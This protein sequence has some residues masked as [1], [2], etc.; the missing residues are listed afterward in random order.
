MNRTQ[1]ALALSLSSIFFA[2]GF[3][4]AVGHAQQ[5]A[6]G[7]LKTVDNPGGG[8]FVYGS[9]TN[10]L[11]QSDA[12]VFM[13]RQ[14]HGHFGDRP[15][16]GKLFQSRDGSSL[17]TFFTLTAKT[18]GNKSMAG[19]VI[20]SMPKGST[21]QA[22]VLYDDVKRF[23]TTEPSMMKTLGALLQPDGAMHNSAAQGRRGS[24]VPTPPSTGEQ[25]FPATAGDNSAVISLPAGWKVT[26][27]SGG[28]L[29]AEGSHGE[30][31]GL[32]MLYQGIFDPRNPQ[33]RQAMSFSRGPHLVCALS[34]D[35]FENYVNVLNQIRQTRGK[36]TGT[37]NKISERNLPS[38]NTEVQVLEAIYT[39]DFHDGKGLR[40]GSARVGAIVTRGLPSWAMTVSATN[41]P[42]PL[43]EEEAS[44]MTAVI[45]SYH[46]NN[47]VI[48]GES[49]ADM[50]RIRAQGE[51]NKRQADAINARRE[52]NTAAYDSHMKDIDRN[53][54]AF[55]QHMD[56]IDRSSK[57]FQD[58]VL[59]RSVVV[60]NDYNER[61][62]LSN[63]YADSLVKANPDR[64]QIVPNQ[65]MIKG[66]D[67]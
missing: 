46:Q 43:A 48:A 42:V 10:Q 25:L 37:F 29:T 19:L 55:N 52:A 35:M 2:I 28:Q 12:M 56:D 51:A 58:Y 39:V 17:A 11:S 49:R 15:Q 47:S 61:G 7:G 4:V 21:P 66:R 22:A 8:Q 14:V 31:V 53:S 6:Q 33:S 5:P 57:A 62:T 59:D 60:D 18:Q 64:F 30:M 50:D 65:N 36:S 16:V 40:K 20:V 63:G 24:A 34:G 45:A 54:D 41:V 26:G 38:S 67:Y 32:G 27:V 1:T 44:T 3:G 23:A 9:L 13:L